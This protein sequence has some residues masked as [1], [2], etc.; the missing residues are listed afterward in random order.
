MRSDARE[1]RSKARLNATLSGDFIRV[2]SPVDDFPDSGL[3]RPA[4]ATRAS[5]P[6]DLAKVMSAKLVGMLMS[7]NLKVISLF[8]MKVCPTW[9]NL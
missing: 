6:T 4:T 1:C 3:L 5:A 9:N 2:I 7:L 8:A